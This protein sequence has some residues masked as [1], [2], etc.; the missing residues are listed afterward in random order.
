MHEKSCFITLT[1]SPEELNKRGNPDS[2]DVRDFQLFMKRLRK[3]HQHKIRFF[4][5]GEYGEKNQRPHYHAL[6]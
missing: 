6:I 1:F 4:N 3:K 5:C 2:L